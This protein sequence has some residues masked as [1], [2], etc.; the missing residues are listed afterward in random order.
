MSTKRDD[1]KTLEALVTALDEADSEA[2]DDEILQ[3]A[4]LAGINTSAEAAHTK[5]LLLNVV[6]QFQK[7]AL[8]EAQAGYLQE[9]QSLSSA[10]YALPN[11]PEQR[12]Q[13]FEL[14]VAKQPQ[15]SQMY[16]TQHRDLKDLTDADVDSYLEDLAAL[17][18]LNDLFGD[19]KT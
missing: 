18:I 17:G 1:E 6:T 2:T 5:T 11:S 7:R 15:Y 19:G 12:R 16:T 4:K 9:V 10:S 13:L 3:E 14:V 8:R